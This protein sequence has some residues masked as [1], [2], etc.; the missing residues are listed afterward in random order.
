MKCKKNTVPATNHN[1]R[2]RHRH[3]HCAHISPHCSV[4]DIL[5]PCRAVF[6]F[7]CVVYLALFIWIFWERTA[8]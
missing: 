5:S 3:P 2:P 8:H 6:G 4:A 7:L 1:H